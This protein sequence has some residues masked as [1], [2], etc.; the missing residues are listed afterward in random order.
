[1]I[2]QSLMIMNL[3][4]NGKMKSWNN[5]NRSKR[6]RQSKKPKKKKENLCGSIYSWIYIHGKGV[7]I[8]MI[9]KQVCCGI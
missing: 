8:N 3:V 6:T 5:N 2:N 4:I 7:E 1:M 9:I